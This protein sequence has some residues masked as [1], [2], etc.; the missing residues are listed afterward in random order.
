M[1]PVE[2]ANIN[3]V[4]ISP[5]NIAQDISDHVSHST[6]DI[7]SDTD[8]EN[9]SFDWAIN[10][11]FRLLPQELCPKIQQEKTSLKPLSGIEQLMESRSVPLLFFPN[12]I[13]WRI[14]QNLSK[15]EL[16]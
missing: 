16:I 3:P 12:Q 8:T 14:Q 2:T 11:V 10:E 5:V 9:W 1:Q 6:K 13:W 15:T 4:N 7:G